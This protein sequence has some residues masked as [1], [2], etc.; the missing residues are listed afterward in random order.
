MDIDIRARHTDV[1]ENI[2]EYILERGQRIERYFEGV[3]RCEFVLARDA[4]AHVVDVKVHAP[5]SDLTA[6]SSDD[7]LRAAIDQAMDKIERQVR[8]LKSRFKK[9]P[10]GDRAAG[11]QVPEAAEGEPRE[12]TFEDVV[13][14][15]L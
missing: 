13:K 1:A 15:E 7:D 2:K 3:S 14:E 9:H 10:R 5:R 12:E 6:S 8:K 4:N 11:S